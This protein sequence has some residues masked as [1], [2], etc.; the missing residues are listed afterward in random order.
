LLALQTQEQA[1]QAEQR[2]IR[3]DIE[4]Q[5]AAKSQGAAE[6]LALLTD[7]RDAQEQRTQRRQLYAQRL[8]AA[9][10]QRDLARACVA[11]QD[12]AVKALEVERQQVVELLED[13]RQ[14]QKDCAEY[15]RQLHVLKR[16]IENTSVKL[17]A[18]R[19]AQQRGDTAIYTSHLQQEPPSS[20]SQHSVPPTPMK[21]TPRQRE[22]SADNTLK[23]HSS[24]VS[25]PRN[26]SLG[27]QFV[28]DVPGCM[29]GIPRNVFLRVAAALNDE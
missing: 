7:S 3:E 2:A 20:F 27:Q 14:A 10:K 4:R 9:I 23:P 19:F 1:R 24:E 11:K 15:A 29:C 28:C 18:A 26:I 16:Q 22:G 6:L 21:K 25:T 8:A 13:A 12:S 5:K 17:N